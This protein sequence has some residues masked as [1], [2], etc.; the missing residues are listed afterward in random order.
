VYQAGDFA[1][2]RVVAIE[3]VGAFLDWGLEK[4]LFLPFSEQIRELK[5]G[6]DVVVLLYIDNNDRISSTMRIE[7]RTDKDTSGYKEEQKVDLLVFDETELGYKAV[8]NNQHVG[9]LYKNE[10]FQELR[11]G[12]KVTGYV[13][14]VRDDGKV[15]LILQPFGNKGSGAIEDRIL[16]ML[17]E[18]GGFLPITDKTT[19][20]KIYDMFG[21]SKKK[22]K[23]ALGGIYKK[24]LITISP[25]GIRLVTGA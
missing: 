1:V 9:I 21:V 19:P 16:G 17:K 23:I 24:R 8:I 5:M 15:D 6:E 3:K 25:D 13:K 14:K 12:D 22:Y 18:Q 7:K 11:Y 20:E 10:V 4:D 2:L